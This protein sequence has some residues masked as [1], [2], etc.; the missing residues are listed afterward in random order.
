[1]W[2]FM[3]F[4]HRYPMPFKK[5]LL[6]HFEGVKTTKSSYFGENTTFPYI[7]VQNRCKFPS[8]TISN[9][10]FTNICEFKFIKI[11]V[12]ERVYTGEIL[13]H[14][15]I[16]LLCPWKL[17]KNFFNFFCVTD[18]MLHTKMLTQGWW[19]NFLQIFFQNIYL[20]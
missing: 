20:I 11:C 5:I 13:H 10:D 18:G 12:C 17:A 14:V 2:L 15:F 9:K 1:M 6:V 3:L 8:V 19:C 16:F 4:I 7:C